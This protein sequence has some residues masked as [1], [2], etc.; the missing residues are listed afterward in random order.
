MTEF[1]GFDEAVVVDIE[2]TGLDPESD[3]VITLSMIRA[4]F[5]ALQQDPSGL[6]GETMD[7][8]VHPQ[9][10]IPARASRVHGIT[11]KDVADKGPF[12]DVAQQVRDFIG[13]RPII[14][15]NASFDKKF[16]TAE[17]KRAGVKTLAR[18]KSYCTM[19]RFQLFNHGQRKGSTLD[20]AAEALGVSSRTGIKHDASEDTRITFEI[21]GLFY[22]MDNG[23]RIPGGQ[24]KPPSRRKVHYERDSDDA[25]SDRIGC[26]TLIAIIGPLLWW[27]VS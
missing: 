3:R 24:P 1:C 25:G 9:R 26:I 4:D 2:T 14:A 11:N 5:A 18:N 17:F 20:D 12:A 21:A 6:H 22:L 16:L 15:H 23:I 7:V 27:F 8:L 10:P 19:R 13:N